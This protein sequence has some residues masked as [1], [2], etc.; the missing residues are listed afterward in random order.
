[1]SDIIDSL[2]K[3]NNPDSDDCLVNQFDE[4]LINLCILT[5]D[6]GGRFFANVPDNAYNDP[7]TALRSDKRM[8]SDFNY[9]DKRVGYLNQA[10]TDFSFIGPDREP[11]EI[12]SIDKLLQVADTILSTGIPNYRMARI[13]IKSGL[14]VEVWE[15]HL[16]DYADKRVLQYIKFGYPL[17]LNNP[18]ESKKHFNKLNSRTY[19]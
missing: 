3:D 19:S 8:A 16:H 1:M 13:P 6:D 2:I 7:S 11:V 4:G 9:P 12:T 15:R 10:V 18:N 17:S 5:K 14:N